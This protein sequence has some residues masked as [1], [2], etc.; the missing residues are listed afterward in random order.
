ML[1]KFSQIVNDFGIK[2][3]GVLHIGAN[4]G[5]EAEEYYNNG[6][7]KTVWIEANPEIMPSLN[8]HIS[9]YPS[10]ISI[11]ATCHMVNNLHQVLHI[12]NN[13]SESSS[14]LSFGTHSTV[15]PDVKVVKEIN[16][17]T[18]IIEG[19]TIPKT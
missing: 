12:T 2:P 13:N 5:Q 15:H 7:K 19:I 9:A 14:I 1:Y 11:N 6:V 3:T 10:A 16:V 18:K 8:K 4:T 17:T